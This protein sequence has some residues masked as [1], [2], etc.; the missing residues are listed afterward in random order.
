[1]GRVILRLWARAISAAIALTPVYFREDTCILFDLRTKKIGALIWCP[2]MV[3]FWSFSGLYT[4]RET[5]HK[6]SWRHFP[7]YEVIFC[8]KTRLRIMRGCIYISLT[9]L[10]NKAIDKQNRNRA[11]CSAAVGAVLFICSYSKKIY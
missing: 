3:A 9:V 1:M 11:G 8:T 5:N 10:C 6:F 4:V 2:N 7:I